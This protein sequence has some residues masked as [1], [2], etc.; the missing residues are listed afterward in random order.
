MQIIPIHL[1]QIFSA[2]A[3]IIE[4]SRHE[5]LFSFTPDDS[6][7][8]LL[9]FNGSTIYEKH[10]LSTNPVDILSFNNNFIPTDIALELIF[11]GKRTG[12][13]YNVT[14]DVYIG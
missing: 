2:H 8:D 10:N 9:G 13:F 7:R 4:T 6:V 11:K 14:M 12:I 3:S 5:T 1:N